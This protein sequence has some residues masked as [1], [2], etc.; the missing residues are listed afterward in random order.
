LEREARVR[1]RVCRRE[2]VTMLS[3]WGLE[4]M[5][6]AMWWFCIGSVRVWVTPTDGR[7]EVDE[8]RMEVVVSR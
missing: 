7:V 5:I 6:V 8:Q 1:V 2:A 3:L 4:R